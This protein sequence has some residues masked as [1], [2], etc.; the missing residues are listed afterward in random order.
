M[1]VVLNMLNDISTLDVEQKF[2]TYQNQ[3]LF[4]VHYAQIFFNTFIIIIIIV[5]I[6][7]VVK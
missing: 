7:V 5:I 3:T 6:V 4:S 1:Y 2:Y